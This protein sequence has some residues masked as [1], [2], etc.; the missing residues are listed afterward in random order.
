MVTFKIILTIPSR[1]DYTLIFE[2]V[3]LGIL[4]QQQRISD[5][6]LRTLRDLHPLF[7][8]SSHSGLHFIAE[9]QRMS[10]EDILEKKKKD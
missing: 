3:Q 6:R 9:D 5:G 4:I 10:T 2:S 1:Y 8:V 7:D